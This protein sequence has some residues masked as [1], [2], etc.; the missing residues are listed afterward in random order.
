M[1]TKSKW[2]GGVLTYFDPAKKYRY[3]SR[4]SAGSFR[5]DFLT[6]TTN[7]G[8]G[9]RANGNP[10]TEDITGSAPPVIS[11]VA[12]GS[13]GI[14][15]CALTSG[16]E[17]QDAT[18]HW[19]DNRHFDL[20]RGLIFQAYARATVLPTSNGTLHIALAGDH[21][22]GLTNTTYNVGF[23]VLA[24]GAL[25][26]NIDDNATQATVSTGLTLTVNQWYCFRIESLAKSNIRAYVDGV[27]VCGS[28]TFNYAGSA[29]ANSTLQPF[30]GAY[31]ASGTGVGTLQV[32]SVDLWWD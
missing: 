18:L 28:T 24:S 1:S 6:Y 7:P 23:T 29:G 21:A 20:D 30:L 10:W 32:D 31:K 13:G 22:A 5:D 14:L 17:A 19:D 11:Y 26:F 8:D 27:R 9:S 16:S 2:L 12:D 15:S 25:S 3:T 4:E